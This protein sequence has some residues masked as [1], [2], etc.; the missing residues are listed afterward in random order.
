MACKPAPHRKNTATPSSRVLRASE[1]KLQ[2]LPGEFSTPCELRSQLLLGFVW[3][4][5][6][7]PYVLYSLSIAKVME[8]VK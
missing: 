4:V 5:L 8:R 6:R 2:G 3:F 1:Q 7:L